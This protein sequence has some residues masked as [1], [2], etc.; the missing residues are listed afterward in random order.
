MRFRCRGWS[1][2]SCTALSSVL[3]NARLGRG[4]R[5]RVWRTHFSKLAIGASA[6]STDVDL[7]ESVVGG[8]RTCSDSVQHHDEE[9][10][11]SRASNMSKPRRQAIYRFA[12]FFRGRSLLFLISCLAM[13]ASLILPSAVT[14]ALGQNS[15][16][17]LNVS[18]MAQPE[19]AGSIKRHDGQLNAAWSIHSS[20]DYL[21]VGQDQYLSNVCY[22]PVTYCFLPQYAPIGTPCW[23]ATPYG[24]SSGYIR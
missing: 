10:L 9:I 1:H 7:E 23:C 22:T 2:H 17:G 4:R 18:E 12:M 5:T 3:Y 6:R 24:P 14:A 20:Y 8:V 21:I 19:A 16:P 13:V 15:R 11:L